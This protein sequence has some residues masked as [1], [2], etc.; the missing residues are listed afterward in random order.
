MFYMVIQDKTIIDV[1]SE[2][3][4]VR[5]QVVHNRLMNCNKEY[6]EGILSSDTSTIW[7]C[8]DLI[9]ENVKDY[10]S[11]TLIE[12]DEDKYNQLREILEL[13]QSIDYEQKEPESEEKE[14]TE[15][16][17]L[18]LDFVRES[19]I[20]E[21]SNECNKKIILG[22]DIKLSDGEVHHFS[23]TTYDQLMIDKLHDKANNGETILPW[24]EDDGQCKFYSADDIKAINNAMESLVLWHQT[25]FNSLKYYIKNISELSEIRD[26]YYGIEIPKEY[27]SVVLIYLLNQKDKDNGV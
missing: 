16:D 24:H 18:T 2:I 14:P 4:Y 7:Y 10:P 23:L 21:M 8:P 12:I 9:A 26:I 25:Y 20:K 5:T 13:N 22:F 11:V 6:A 15:E 19:K 17:L 3:S 1:L 27:Q